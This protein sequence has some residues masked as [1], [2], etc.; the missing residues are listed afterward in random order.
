MKSIVVFCGANPGTDPVYREQAYLLGKTLAEQDIRLIY[1]GAAVGL[2]KSVADGAM[3]NGGKVSGVFPR[4]LSELEIAHTNLTELIVVE[5]MHERKLKMHEL[6][7]AVIALPG[8]F[9]TL[10]ELFEMLTWGQLGLHQKPIG[11]LNV[12]GF[13]NDLIAL[14]EKMVTT[15]FLKA[16]NKEMVLIADT[17]PALLAKLKQHKEE[18]AKKWITREKT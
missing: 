5:T 7:D 10:E 11:L 9:G 16:K 3:E 8:G 6:S 12:R 14:A 15:G 2:M 18:V 13:Y 4:F 17:I 1:G